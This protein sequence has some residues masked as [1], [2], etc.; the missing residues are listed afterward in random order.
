[1]SL[2]GNLEDLGLGEILQIVSLSRKSGVL[3]LNSLDRD[4]RVIFHDGQVIRASA[5][6]FPENIGDLVIRAGMVDIGTLK[7]ALVIQHERDD[8]RRIG[9]ILVSDFGVDREAIET[10]VREQ[11]E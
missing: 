1:M 6:T 10:V 9:D 7:K 4:G 11:V 8:G 5:S 3:Q 2:V